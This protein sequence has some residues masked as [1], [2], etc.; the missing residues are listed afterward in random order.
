MSLAKPMLRVSSPGN[1]PGHTMYGDWALSGREY[2]YIAL[3]D[4]AM[5][6][7]PGKQAETIRFSDIC[8]KPGDW[9]GGDDFSGERYEAAKT[10]YPG[11]L[12]HAMPNPCDLPYRMV[13]GRRR[14]E[15]LRR[16]GSDS[17]KFFVFEFEDCKEFIFD[18]QIEE[19]T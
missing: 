6:H 12:I 4:L 17:G 5:K 16:G 2:S 13:D 19:D 14:M 7:M 15:K 8:A 3:I 10:K 18:F 9:F 1:I 11:I